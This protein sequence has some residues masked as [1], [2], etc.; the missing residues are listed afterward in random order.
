MQFVCVTDLPTR[1]TERPLLVAFVHWLIRSSVS[2]SVSQ[3]VYQ[4]IFFFGICSVFR[5]SGQPAVVLRACQP[6]QCAV[7]YG[8]FGEDEDLLRW[9]I[10][11][12]RNQPI[13]S[14]VSSSSRS[15][16]LNLA[17]TVSGFSCACRRNQSSGVEKTY[18]SFFLLNCSS[19]KRGSAEKKSLVARPTMPTKTCFFLFG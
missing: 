3:Y 7:T 12:A 2:Q 10:D 4:S 18:A 5:R 13:S 9:L 14:V 17:K 11:Y 15:Q 16:T 1:R 19:L 8:S 6:R